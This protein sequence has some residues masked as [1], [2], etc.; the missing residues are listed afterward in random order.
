MSG[1]GEI[2]S[3]LIGVFTSGGP[4]NVGDPQPHLQGG[5]KNPGDPQP[6]LQ[7]GTSDSTSLSLEALEELIALLSGE[8]CSDS[9]SASRAA[10]M[11]IEDKFGGPRE[12][13]PEDPGWEQVYGGSDSDSASKAA[14]MGIEDKYGGP[15]A[16][17]PEDPG[18]EKVHGGSKND[19]G[20]KAASMGIEDKFG[21]PR[22]GHP[23]D[24]R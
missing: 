9:D 8:G 15:R 22:P 7:E 12:D 10:E 23:E 5:P 6:H 18:W 19:S 1:I 4:R 16:D 2:S 21:G 14:E 24:P 13:H 11:G 17:H 20:S 3:M